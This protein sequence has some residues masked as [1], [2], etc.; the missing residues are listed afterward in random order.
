MVD[1]GSY[2]PTLEDIYEDDENADFEFDFEDFHFGALFKET[3]IPQHEG[4]CLHRI[5]QN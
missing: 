5:I 1:E 4:N 2:Q 3:F